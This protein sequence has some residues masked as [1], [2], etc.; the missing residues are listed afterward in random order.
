MDIFEVFMIYIFKKG[1]YLSPI[2]EECKS[3]FDSVLVNTT[4]SIDNF[5]CSINLY[6]VLLITYN[7]LL[8]NKVQII[9]LMFS[10][11]NKIYVNKFTLL[12]IAFFKHYFTDNDNSDVI[13]EM[14]L[15]DII[16]DYGIMSDVVDFC[17]NG[18]LCINTMC[19][20]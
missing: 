14:Q 9:C 20:G 10:D 7:R 6:D 19:V 17:Q 3:I 11:G 18:S 4:K 8:K 15:G 16:D 13:F 1:E 2:E 12:H 5:K